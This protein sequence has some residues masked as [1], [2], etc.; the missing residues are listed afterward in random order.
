[1][2]KNAVK[3]IKIGSIPGTGHWVVLRDEG[4]DQYT[5]RG[6]LLSCGHTTLKSG[7][8]LRYNKTASCPV[9]SQEKKERAA[10]DTKVVE[11]FIIVEATDKR[12]KH[13][14]RT[15][16]LRCE[17]CGSTMERSTAQ[18]SQSRQRGH[19]L[20]CPGC[21]DAAFAAAI[22]NPPLVL[23]PGQAASALSWAKSGARSVLGKDDDD[24]DDV[25]SE[26]VMV[27]LVK[28]INGSADS[29]SI[30]KFVFRVAQVLAKRRWNHQ[31]L[32]QIGPSKGKDGDEWNDVFDNLAVPAKSEG[33]KEST[34]SELQMLAFNSLD[35]ADREFLAHYSAIKIKSKKQKSRWAA[36]VSQSKA[37]LNS[38]LVE[39]GN[40]TESAGPGEC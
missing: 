36:L 25:A 17:A 10:V 23:T 1:V 19:E 40:Q 28:G 24:V 37:K 32:R 30:G 38:L 39:I 34:E 9:C 7:W 11:G 4:E 22:I 16:V 20:K 15:V 3:P 18:V 12:D 35:Q 21:P 27:V 8:A 2:R 29:V 26:A 31:S 13:G 5:V 6:T 14:R 33:S